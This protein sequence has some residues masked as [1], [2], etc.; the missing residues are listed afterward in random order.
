MKFRMLAE[1]LVSGFWKDRK[2]DSTDKVSIVDPDL[3]DTK[4]RVL[5]GSSFLPISVMVAGIT[6]SITW[7]FTFGDPVSKDSLKSSFRAS[8]VMLLPPI[9]NRTISE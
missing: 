5:L 2:C 1:S 9:P 7:D 8:D 6:V 4:N 3:L